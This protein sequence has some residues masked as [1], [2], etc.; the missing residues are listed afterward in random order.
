MADE[1]FKKGLIKRVTMRRTPM[2]RLKHALY[3]LW[4]QAEIKSGKTEPMKFADF[5][6][7]YLDELTHSICI[8]V[9]R[10]HEINLDRAERDKAKEERRGNE[11]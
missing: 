6:N 10:T 7:K 4:E 2:D 9:C 11:S 5:Q 8:F 1:I 3:E